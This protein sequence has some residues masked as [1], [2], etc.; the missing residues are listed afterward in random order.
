MPFRYFIAN[1][2]F[3][4]ICQFSQEVAGQKTLANLN[5]TFP[6]D[7]YPIGRLDQDSEGLLLLTSD[8]SL[9]HRLLNP[10]FAH[11]RT[12]LAQIEGIPNPESL[13][14]FRKGVTIKI[15]KK[16]YDTLPAECKPV[17]DPSVYFD[18]QPLWVRLPLPKSSGNKPMSWL[19]V[20]LTEGKNR[21]V[22][23]M[24]AAIGHPCLRLIRIKIVDL[25]LSNLQP[26]EVKE[27]TSE[28][29]LNLLHI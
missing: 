16:L 13:E 26:D 21:Q 3:D 15:E 11:R 14:K 23:R 17:E 27:L 18:N 10:Q 19:E 24:C 1:K 8:R 29:M 20:T 6:K 5:F 12:Y 25:S 4:T 7:V 2:P 28:E 22:R 9:N